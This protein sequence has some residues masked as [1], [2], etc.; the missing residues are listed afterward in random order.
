[1][2]T[3]SKRKQKQKKGK[4]KQKALVNSYNQKKDYENKR[5]MKE[6]LHKAWK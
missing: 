3:R 1:M 5:K 4:F 6:K 2:K